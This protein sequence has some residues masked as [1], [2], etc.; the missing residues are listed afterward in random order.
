MDCVKD[1]VPYF[2]ALGEA[3]FLYDNGDKKQVEISWLEKERLGMSKFHPTF[4]T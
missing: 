1:P 4:V 2:T 3:I